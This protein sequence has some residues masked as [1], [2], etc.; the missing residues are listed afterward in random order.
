MARL[1]EAAKQRRVALQWI[2]AHCGIQG[3]EAADELAKLGAR[4]AQPDNSVSFIEKRAL[5]K[6]AMRPKPTRDAIQFLD[7]RQQ[8]MI[9]RLRTGHNRLKSH[10]NRKLKLA[11]SPTCDCGLSDQ[12]ADH[13]LQNCPFFQEQRETVWPA[14]VPLQV[15]L[16]GSRQDL[17]RTATFIS[18]THL[19]L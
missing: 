4:E 14:T 7:R 13:I 18:L 11:P 19:T 2:P 8:V 15:K 3:N 10:M 1:Q 6:A 9:M 12:N 16:H 5:V 17:E